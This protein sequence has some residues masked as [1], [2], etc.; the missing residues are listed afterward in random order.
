MKAF[1]AKLT[2]I[3]MNLSYQT[4]MRELRRLL[5][6]QVNCSKYRLDKFLRATEDPEMD[7]RIVNVLHIICTDVK[8]TTA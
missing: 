7:F 5:P 2:R 6:P 8:S 1:S 3:W 4:L